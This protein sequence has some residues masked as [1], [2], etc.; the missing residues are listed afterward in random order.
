MEE[1]VVYTKEEL[2]EAMSSGA[3]QIIVYG[4]FADKLHSTKKIA[5][6]GAAG[7]AAM[8]G[9]GGVAALTGPIGA[10]AVTS[11]AALSGMEIAAIIPAVAIGVTVL[12]AL[13]KDY[14]EI[15]FGAGVLKLRKKQVKV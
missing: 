5:L 15:E 8:L 7:I 9:L 3:D 12:V 14:E 10:A 6:V 1:V 2:E 11:V 4:E 13:Y